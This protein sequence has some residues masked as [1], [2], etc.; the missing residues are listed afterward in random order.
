MG[1]FVEQAKNSPA[2]MA[3]CLVLLPLLSL[4][5]VYVVAYMTSSLSNFPGPPLAG[6]SKQATEMHL[7]GN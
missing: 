3:A 7:I 6:K 4:G 1:D 2:N 5:L